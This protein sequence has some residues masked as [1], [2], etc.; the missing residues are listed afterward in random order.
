MTNSP[1]SQAKQSSQSSRTT[2]SSSSPALLLFFILLALNCVSSSL[3]YSS[4]ASHLTTSVATFSLLQPCL[5]ARNINSNQRV[6]A[7]SP[8]DYPPLEG[9][10][11]AFTQW[12]PLGALSHPREYADGALATQKLVAA[13]LIPLNRQM[14][15]GVDTRPAYFGN[16]FGGEK[17]A[18]VSQL[19]QAGMR[20]LVLDLWWDGVDLGWQLC[21]R[22]KRSG[23]QLSTIRLALENMEKVDELQLQGMGLPDQILNAQ[24]LP[25]KKPLGASDTL[26][27]EAGPPKVEK[28]SDKKEERKGR[29]D[30]KGTAK[31][32][33]T[34]MPEW[35][36]RK[37]PH[38]RSPPIRPKA[39]GKDRHHK[40]SNTLPTPVNRE[41][42]APH[43]GGFHRLAV[44]KGIMSAYDKAKSADQTVD[45]ITC[46]TGEDVVMLL[47]TIQS[48]IQQSSKE[49]LEDVIVL[50]LNLNELTNSSLGS[51]TPSPP[52]TPPPT[53]N[54]T[55]AAPM[56]SNEEFFAMVQSPNTNNTI[57]AALPN[58][59]SLKE[60]FLDTF[61]FMIYSP[62]QLESDRQDLK[63]TW[64]KSGPVGIDYY[65][66]TVDPV[67]GRTQTTTGWPTSD[68]LTDVINRRIIVGFGANN[69]K[70]NTTYNIADD[71][72][73]IYR[74]GFLG[75]S[76]TNSSLIKITSSLNREQC[77]FPM[78]GMMMQPTGREE[79][80]TSIQEQKKNLTE[81]I[82]TEVSW[83]FAS[84]SDANSAP[85]TYSTGQLAVS[86][87]VCAGF[88]RHGEHKAIMSV[89]RSFS[90]IPKQ[91]KK[92]RLYVDFHLWLREW[93]HPFL[94]QSRQP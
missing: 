63:A 82:T 94:T 69:L 12:T 62:Y 10:D 57:K 52:P 51:R 45:G 19:L 30:K 28:R 73:T 33:S 48:W 16:N 49:E 21:P 86:V 40:S 7:P 54:H 76:M 56:L 46:S 35:F 87:C 41:A 29:N 44:S 74:P 34:P 71:F 83:S 1:P 70:L 11:F 92:N 14:W 24:D 37:R 23:A 77:N 81:S 31:E 64:W 55:T 39:R 8:D 80:W 20:R 53:A 65:N 72:T 17:I 13:P 91:T 59:I 25:D 79:N 67:T 9:P 27:E 78:P 93:D 4:L 85:W 18:N 2:S 5:A 75:P 88:K 90:Y 6:D 26:S 38:H 68:Y 60:I 3:Q 66:T 61:K 42:T 22:I 84:M 89:T 50:V 32:A 43:R 36:R 58:M 47:E 15:P